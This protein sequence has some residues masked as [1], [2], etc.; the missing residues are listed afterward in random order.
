TPVREMAEV[1][2]EAT[3]I[4]HT[5]Q[6]KETLYSIAKKYEVG[7]EEVKK[8]NAIESNELK[9]GQQIRINKSR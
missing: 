2:S 9:I 3:S 4:T 7:V 1:S 5:V 8:W 6:P